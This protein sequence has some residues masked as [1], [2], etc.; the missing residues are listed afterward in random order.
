M[1][2][3]GDLAEKVGVNRKLLVILTALKLYF[4]RILLSVCNKY[5]LCFAS[6]FFQFQF[7]KKFWLTLKYKFDTKI[8]VTGKI[9]LQTVRII[10]VTEKF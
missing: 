6:G 7:W 2:K 8:T 5:N 1:Q 10:T 9:H 4:Y 3:V